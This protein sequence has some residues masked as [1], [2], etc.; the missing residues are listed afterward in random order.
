MPERLE[1]VRRMISG[2]YPKQQWRPNAG[3]IVRTV[4]QA[5]GIAKRFGVRI[6]ED[7]EFFV[8]EFGE[9]D[10]E[11][12]ARG[13]RVTKLAGSVVRWSDLV[14]DLTGKVPFRIRPDIL[15]SDEAIVA[16]LAHEMY[17]LEKL[18]PILLKG[19]TSIE[20]FIGLTCPGN[21]GNLHDEAWDVADALVERMR[22]DEKK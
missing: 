5:V 18:R 15:A 8:D 13:P 9:L 14:H 2:Q 11:T 10:K 6:P 3:G 4:E 16:V 22:G 19:K 7:A 17:E 1:A 21:P 20:Q 12:T